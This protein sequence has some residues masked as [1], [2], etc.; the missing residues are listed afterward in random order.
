MSTL[1]KETIELLDHLIAICRDGEAGFRLAAAAVDE[2]GL[3]EFFRGLSLQR[4][5]FAD[6]LE[7]VARLLGQNR[8]EHGGSTAGDLHR[9]WLNLRSVF[10][11]HDAR[12]VLSECE[13]GEQHAVAA[14]RDALEQP[15]LP[16]QLLELIEAQ[17]ATIGH[18][19]RSLSE[20]LG[21]PA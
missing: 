5:G 19:A 14:Y 3:R 10:G 1:S 11:G 2:L 18:T 13:R 6:E 20:R 12:A 4:A 8:F 16:W 17:L 9:A 21:R 7:T 15:D